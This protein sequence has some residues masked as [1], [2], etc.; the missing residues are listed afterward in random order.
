VPIA[1]ALVCV[2][3]GAL[4]LLSSKS[5]DDIQPPLT[6]SY[7]EGPKLPLWDR[8]PAI[9]FWIGRFD[10]RSATGRANVTPPA[11]HPELEGGGVF[12]AGVVRSDA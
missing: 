10:H 6:A 3:A 2:I 7:V 4:A 1:P 9:A 8:L 5:A 12:V 11:Q